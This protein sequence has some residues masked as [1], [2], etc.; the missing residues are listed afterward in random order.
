MLSIESE[1]REWNG[2]ESKLL[3]SLEVGA[4]FPKSFNDEEGEGIV[5]DEVITDVKLEP[6]N[7]MNNN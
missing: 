4:L 1:S 7:I 5:F 6:E 2:N 3:I